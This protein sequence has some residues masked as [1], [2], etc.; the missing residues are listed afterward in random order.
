MTT[1]SLTCLLAITL[2][3]GLGHS[4]S[5]LA[6]DSTSA[7][8]LRFSVSEGRVHNEF[9]RDGHIAAHLV[10]TSGPAP[11]LV[12][13]FPAGNSGTALWFDAASGPFA[14]LPEAELTGAHRSVKEGTLRGISAELEASGAPITIRHA[15]LS[16]VRVIRDY[17]Y[18]GETPAEVLVPPQVQANTIVWQ[19]PR[20]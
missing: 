6:A 3:F 1:H 2:G 12:V 4:S 8:P 14:W 19:R 17:G 5:L 18:T 11:R 20:L 15:I 9:F 7:S 13:A 10:L 16:S